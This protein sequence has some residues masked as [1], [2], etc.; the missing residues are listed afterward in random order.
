MEDEPRLTIPSIESKLVSREMAGS[1][2]K[3]ERP[4]AAVAG[5][6]LLVLGF[7]A[8]LTI[9]TLVDFGVT[10][11]TSTE[12]PLAWSLAG[13]DSNAGVPPLNSLKLM[14]SFD[15]VICHV[16]SFGAESCGLR[17]AELTVAANIGAAG[18]AL[19][20][21]HE[22]PR[23]LVLGRGR[24]IVSGGIGRGAAVGSARSTIR[25]SSGGGLRL[26]TKSE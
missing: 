12:S 20:E 1:M 16:V 19:E 21:T 5:G 13:S 26:G 4:L 11:R 17:Y 9:L 24:G 8:R 15:A 6:L 14:E 25:G 10:G 18:L 23:L 3:T 7:L 2:V 22:T